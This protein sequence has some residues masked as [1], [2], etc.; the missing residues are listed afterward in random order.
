MLF[1]RADPKLFNS[2]GQNA[3]EIASFWNQDSALKALKEF[4][5]APS[6][7]RLEL[8]NFFS[9]SAVDRQSYR[10]SDEAEIQTVMKTE[11]ARFVVFAELRL[12]VTNMQPPKHGCQV[13]YL[14]WSEIEKILVNI[15]EHER[16][17]IFL[18]VGDIKKGIL[19]REVDE[20]DVDKYAYFGINFKKVSEANELTFF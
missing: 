11:K 1:L 7:P 15:P 4:L 6:S 18:G 3:L 16:D 13:L 2:S 5:Q 17:I 8:V 14:T 19:L 12:L 20:T 10:R 9:H